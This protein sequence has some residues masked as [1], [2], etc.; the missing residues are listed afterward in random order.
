MTI[1]K[2]AIRSFALE[3]DPQPLHL[4]LSASEPFDDVVASG[5]HVAS[6]WMRFFVD[7]FLRHCDCRGLP[8]VRELHWLAPVRPGDVLVGRCEVV[9]RSRSAGDGA[10]E[11]LVVDGWLQNQ[12]EQVVMTLQIDARIAQA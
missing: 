9:G 2:R 6:V 4:D 8:R 12:R 5:W 10:V 3:F 1:S 11:S 7:G